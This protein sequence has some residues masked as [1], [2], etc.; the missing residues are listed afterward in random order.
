MM[1]KCR[2]LWENRTAPYRPLLLPRTPAA[3]A[4]ARA[5]LDELDTLLLLLDDDDE[6]DECDAEE[7]EDELIPEAKTDAILSPRNERER[8]GGRGREA[9]SSGA[10]ALLRVS[11]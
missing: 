4:F 6:C 11:E 9:V 1:G 8:E 2:K 5:R 10:R 7:T 3:P